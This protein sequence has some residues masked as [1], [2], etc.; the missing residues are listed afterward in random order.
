M[1]AL[2]TTAEEVA[3]MVKVVE[4]ALDSVADRHKKI[5]NIDIKDQKNKK[6]LILNVCF[7]R[8]ITG[9]VVRQNT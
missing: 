8:C 9:K 6:M 7:A 1:P 5:F 4:V 2:V 3:E